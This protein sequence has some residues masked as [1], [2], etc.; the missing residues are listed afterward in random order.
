MEYPY[1]RGASDRNQAL[2]PY[3]N[4]NEHVLWSGSPCTTRKN[5]AN[6]YALG[7]MLF[8]TGFAVFWT[9]S[10]SFAGGFFWMFGI[11]FL[12]IG[13]FNL[14]QL[15][16]APQKKFPRTVYAVT[17]TRAIILIPSK[18]GYNMTS[19][20]FGSMPGVNLSDIEGDS[21]SIVF[22]LGNVASDK[23]GF[24]MRN[25]NF[26]PVPTDRFLLIDGV[27]EVYHLIIDQINAQK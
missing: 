13:F 23:Y 24:A 19:Y 1:F 3:L 17:D 11:V 16:I 27:N 18:K 22:L 15:V 8:W 6:V 9:L 7:F 26:D 4:E 25:V 20:M 10:A 2:R 21:G 12:V 14:Y 5:K